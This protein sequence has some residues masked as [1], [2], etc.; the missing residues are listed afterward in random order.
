MSSIFNPKK[1]YKDE[2]SYR[3]LKD[4]D[5]NPKKEKKA[6]FFDNLRSLLE[7]L[8]LK[9]GMTL[10]FHHHLRNGDKVLDLVMREI[11]KMKIKNL[12]IAASSFF[13]AHSYLV[14]MFEDQSVI[15][16]HGDY[17]SGEVAKAISMG[18]CK[19]T[20]IITTHGGRSRE[21]LE[22]EL[23]IDIAFIASPCTDKK[24]NATGSQGKSNCGVLGYAIAD[25]QRAKKV[26][27]VTD[28]IEDKL[29]KPEIDGRFV[30]YVLKVDS[31]GDPSKIVSGTT[32]ITKDP[33][34]LKIARDCALLMMQGGYLKNGFNFQ[35]GAGG[36]SLAVADEVKKLMKKNN[37]KGGFASGGITDYLVSMLEE[38]F[39]EKLYDVQCF[40]LGATTSIAKNEN[41]IKMSANDYANINN[42]ENIASFLDVVIL[43][44]SEIDLSYNV[45][46]STTSDGMILGGSGGH[47]DT[48]AGAKL[49]IIVSKLVN[50]RISVIV[51]KVR[52]ITTPKESIDVLVTERG[53]AINPRHDKLIKHLKENSNLRIL[54]IE[55]L[56]KIARDLTG[57]PKKKEKKGRV[58]ALSVYR[59]GS[60][61][62]KIYQV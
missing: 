46:V 28:T 1:H 51:D 25:A 38:G 57:Y 59:D 56:Y 30:D 32:Q 19:E 50:S 11:H 52:T 6:E 21:I 13:P 8:E 3:E 48:A 42:K 43:G 18:K 47:A 33:V 22:G 37:I 36:I 35:T 40:T 26:V 29:N 58:V 7:K 27:L 14:N 17:Y 54:T 23:E 41:H 10:S 9:D 61:L 60:L 2:F 39:F 62:D 53:I 16:L 45:N 44:A 34:G 5:F 20:C 31:I 24:A 4:Y 15:R 12:T 49:S 55:E